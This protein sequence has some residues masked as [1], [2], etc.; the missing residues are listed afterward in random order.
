MKKKKYGFILLAIVFFA[1]ASFFVTEWIKE[2]RILNQPIN[3][4][5]YLIMVDDILYQYTYDL[6]EEPEEPEDGTMK[7][8]VLGKKPYKHEQANFGDV[9]MK[10]WRVEDY[11]VVKSTYSG[12]M[13]QFEEIWY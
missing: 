4:L 3:M 2:Q 8:I 12:V 11:I 7:E 9:G 13:M 10:Y 5:P 6:P 1:A